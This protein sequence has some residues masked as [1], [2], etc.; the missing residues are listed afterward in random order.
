MFRT[1]IHAIA[2]LVRGPYAA[3]SEVFAEII[4]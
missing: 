2:E 1:I 4:R 3:R